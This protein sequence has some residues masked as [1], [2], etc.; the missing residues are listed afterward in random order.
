MRA[1]PRRRK[2]ATAGAGGACAGRP[3]SS[4]NACCWGVSVRVEGGV[5]G[6]WGDRLLDR[7]SSG[8]AAAGAPRGAGW[9][10]HLAGPSRPVKRVLVAAH[11][12]THARLRSRSDL[13]CCVAVSCPPAHLRTSSDHSTAAMMKVPTGEPV[14]CLGRQ[15]P[16]LGSPRPPLGAS[17]CTPAEQAP[18]VPLSPPASR[19][20]P[21]GACTPA[22]R[23][24][25]PPRR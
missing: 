2:C 4:C 13:V 1:R 16:R 23:C 14:R 25:R 11:Q 22:F 8:W 18:A 15:P 21:S 7:Q 10:S 12:G 19:A 17:G 6:W 24:D 3:T 20:V 5:T 9:P